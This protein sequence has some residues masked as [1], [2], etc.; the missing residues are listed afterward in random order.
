VLAAEEDLARDLLE[1]LTAD[2]KK[3]AIVSP[4]AYKDILT[5]ASRKAALEG[6]PSGIA[7]EKMTKKQTELLMTLLAEYAH[8][9]PDQ[10]AQTRMDEIKKAGNNLYFA[11]AGVEQRGGP[12][13]YRIQAPSFLVEYDDTQNNANHIHTVWRDFNGD[14]GLDLL[15]LH[16]RTS[17]QLAQK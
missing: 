4:E 5:A 6:Q 1:S 16:Y 9:V 8:N 3:V 7:A 2:Q 11:W 12:H 14:F 15:S 13:Y 17:H 10:L